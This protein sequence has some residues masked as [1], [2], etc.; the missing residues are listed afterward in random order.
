MLQSRQAEIHLLKTEYQDARAIHANNTLTNG[1]PT[2]FTAFAH[3]NVALIDIS[4]GSPPEMIKTTLDMARRQFKIA[5]ASPLGALYCDMAGADLCLLNGDIQVARQMFERIFTSFRHTFASG[6]SFCLE[7]LAN[8]ECG[9]CDLVTTSQWAVIYLAHAV[10][11]K[12]M[13][14]TLKAIQLV[15]KLAIIEGDDDT[16]MSLFQTALD[17][18]TVMDVHQWRANSMLHMADIIEH[19][20]D[21]PEAVKL[22]TAAKPLFERSSQT[23]SVA[24]LNSKLASVD[25]KSL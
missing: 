8:T 19:H 11:S 1:P 10:T 21:I 24:R 5:F 18:F 9:L 12:N 17:G 3:L 6:A 20:G 25:E 16:G 4:T 22:W 14:N 23:K 13:L 7:R 2:P 15:A